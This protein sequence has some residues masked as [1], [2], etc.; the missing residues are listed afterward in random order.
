L[1]GRK[2]SKIEFDARQPPQ[3]ILQNVHG[4]SYVHNFKVHFKSSG[5]Q[6]LANKIDVSVN[7]D[8]PNMPSPQLVTNEFNSRM[9]LA[10]AHTNTRVRF[11]A[12]SFHITNI[13]Y[14]E[15]MALSYSMGG[16]SMPQQ[17]QEVVTQTASA[18]CRN[19][20]S[21]AQADSKFCNKCGTQL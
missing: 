2:N 3:E 17:P 20:G 1:F 16:N 7:T 11:N 12:S 14:K 10:N 15:S 6:M 19:C 13:E 5:L 18:F 9:V 8:S 21:P 4:F